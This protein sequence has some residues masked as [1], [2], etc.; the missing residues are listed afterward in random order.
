MNNQSHWGETRMFPLDPKRKRPPYEIGVT[1]NARGQVVIYE[2]NN[3]AE[4]TLYLALTMNDARV[5]LR[6]LQEAVA[7]D[8]EGREGT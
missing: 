8:R 4:K 7:Y 1:I 2:N 5:V 3:V 6:G